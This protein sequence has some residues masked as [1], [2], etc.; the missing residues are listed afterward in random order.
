MVIFI[1]YYGDLIKEYKIGDACGT[2]RTR[3]KYAQASLENQMKG[4]PLKT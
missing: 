2:H 3:D 1:N 4:D